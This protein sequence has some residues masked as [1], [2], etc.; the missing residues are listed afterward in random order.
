MTRTNASDV[1]DV[2]DTTLSSSVLSAYVTA[3]NRVVDR[4]ADADSSIDA[5][6]LEDIEKFYAAYLASAQDP[7]ADSRSS[8]SRS[9]SYRDVDGD[10]NASYKEIAVALDP[11]GTIADSDKPSAGVNVL[12]AKGLDE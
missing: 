4:I 9:V 11:T 7:Q 8:A 1:D 3:A 12:D 10:G 2:L 5:A 6:T